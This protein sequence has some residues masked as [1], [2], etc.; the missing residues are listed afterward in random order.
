MKTHFIEEY[1]LHISGIWCCR[2]SIKSRSPF[3]K[4]HSVEDWLRWAFEREDLEDLE[5]N[6]FDPRAMPNFYGQFHNPVEA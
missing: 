2:E 5:Y 4:D 6:S 3:A 1:H